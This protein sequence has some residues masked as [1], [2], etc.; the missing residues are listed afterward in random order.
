[1]ELKA[2][3]NEQKKFFSQLILRLLDRPLVNR[4]ITDMSTIVEL[5]EIHNKTNTCE[6]TF[7]IHR[8]QKNSS[9]QN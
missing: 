3:T 9:F 2:L 7:L 8:L 1:M 4:P 6:L 5:C